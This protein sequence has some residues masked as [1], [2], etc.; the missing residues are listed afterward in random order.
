MRKF[1]THFLFS[2]GQGPDQSEKTLSIQCILV[3]ADILLTM[4]K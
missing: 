2:D 1:G 4:G 3:L